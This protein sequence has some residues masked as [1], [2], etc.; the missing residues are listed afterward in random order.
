M[1]DPTPQPPPCPAEGL[2]DEELLQMAADAQIYRFQATAGDPVQYEPTEPQLINYARA[3]IA[4][5][6]A[7]RPQQEQ[8]AEALRRLRRWGGEAGSHGWD[9]QTIQDVFDWIDAGM[10]GPLPPLPDY[11]LARQGEQS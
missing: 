5:D 7:Q 11:I 10:I 2:S 8:M 1:T 3:A 9:G 6:R 4:A